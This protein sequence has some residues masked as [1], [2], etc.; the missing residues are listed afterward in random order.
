MTTDRIV[1]EATP[2]RGR[3]GSSARARVC[4]LAVVL[5]LLP[6]ILAEGAGALATGAPLEQAVGKPKRG[7]ADPEVR[8]AAPRGSSGAFMTRAGQY[9]F[10]TCG[11]TSPGSLQSSDSTSGHRGS[12][13]Y[14]DFYSIQGD[15]GQVVTI[16]L[17]SESFDPYLILV[18][19]EGNTVTQD[20]NS[21]G[22]PNGWNARITWT[23]GM[24]GEWVVEATS[25]APQ[26]TGSYS[27]SSQCNCL[28]LSIAPQ[29]VTV[30]SAAGT[31]PVA[32]IPSPAGCTGGSW[33][34]LANDQWLNVTPTTG[35]GSGVV[36][37]GWTQNTLLASRMGTATIADSTFTVNQPVGLKLGTIVPCRLLDTRNLDGPFGGP[38]IQAAGSADRLFPLLAAG[39][40]IPADARAIAANVTVVSP[41]AAGDLLVY[42]A[43]LPV[44][45]VASSV[46]FRP[47]RTRAAMSILPLP[48]DGSGIVGVRNRAAGTVD[49]IIDVNGTFVPSSSGSVAAS[50]SLQVEPSPCP[51]GATAC[52]LFPDS[53]VYL[54]DTL[55]ITPTVTGGA[56]LTDWR[57]DYGFHVGAADDWGAGSVM[58]LKQ[59]DLFYP[60][61]GANVPASITLV[62][63]CDP[64]GSGTPSTGLGCWTSVTNN[65]T[66]NSTGLPDF[67]ASNPQARTMTI[68]FEARNSTGSAGPKLF[69]L[70]WEVPAIRLQ[71]SVILLGNPVSALGSDGHPLNSSAGYKWYFGQIPG[72]PMGEELQPYAGCTGPTCTPPFTAQGNYNYWV[73]VPYANGYQSPDCPGAPAAACTSS[74]GYITVMDAVLSV[75]AP[76][77]VL[78]TQ[79]SFQVFVN[80]QQGPQVTAC[81][82]SF[83]YALCFSGD[84]GCAS[85]PSAGWFSLAVSGGQATIPTPAASSSGQTWWLHIRYNYTT[86]SG[87]CGTARKTLSW[88]G[89]IV[90]N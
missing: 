89:T 55:R 43:G 68:A 78:R 36:T 47:G 8:L 16:D 65:G 34:A 41:G 44:I 18:D 82:P 60:G 76:A 74:M 66:E 85:G 28:S 35:T 70:R 42:P 33:T 62:G 20:G 7:Q 29:S 88:Q 3:S 19:P 45:P 58:R 81:S 51:G 80:L 50:A 52:P 30:G 73:S 71:S 26:A 17:A 1:T 56:P 25:D 6:W 84:S 67:D 5:T 75:V 54:G 77:S 10:V 59:P 23:L 37:V 53:T 9:G 86:V 12:N 79:P 24:A 32:V 69:P 90:F 72:S 22:G 38:S 83:E 15:A 27:L 57:F 31:T 46:S 13:Y 2:R 48:A 11:A 64:K 61:D 21:G 87:G 4:R 14:T 39:C 40:G 63:P 49:L